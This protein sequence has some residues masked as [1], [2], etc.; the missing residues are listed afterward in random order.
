MRELTFDPGE[1]RRIRRQKLK[2][3]IVRA[4]P[5]QNLRRLVGRGVVENDPHPAGVLAPNRLENTQ[6]LPSAFALVEKPPELAGAE[7]VSRQAV[8]AA[9]RP[10]RIRASL[11][12]LG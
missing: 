4:R 11:D 7:I 9:G 10:T 5:L 1:P 2:A 12:R 8:R 3:D 6:E